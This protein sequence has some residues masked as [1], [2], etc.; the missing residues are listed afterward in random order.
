MASALVWAALLMLLLI[1]NLREI[2]NR[3]VTLA[4]WYFI[5][6]CFSLAILMI[7]GASYG[8]GLRTQSATKISKSVANGGQSNPQAAAFP[9]WATLR[10]NYFGDSRERFDR[11]LSQ[12]TAILNGKGREAVKTADRFLPAFA[13]V[14][15]AAGFQISRYQVF[16]SNPQKVISLLDEIYETVWGKILNENPD[17]MPDLNDVLQDGAS[18]TKFRNAAQNTVRYYDSFR[19]IYEGSNEQISSNAALLFSTLHEPVK[20]DAA[21]F[22]EWIDGCN[23]RINAKRRALDHAK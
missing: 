19:I 10:R 22:N 6:P 3:M 5:I 8:L 2:R 23:D 15:A 12:L 21:A 1:S 14:S 11:N 18:L 4:S 9:E 13:D 16:K 7:A 20:R 17:Q